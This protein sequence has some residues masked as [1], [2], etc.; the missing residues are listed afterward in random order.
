[1]INSRKRKIMIISIVLFMKVYFSRKDRSMS[2]IM[3]KK[4]QSSSRK[5]LTNIKKKK[6]YNESHTQTTNGE[7]K[8]V[9]FDEIIC[10]TKRKT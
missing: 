10:R 3:R 2:K 6:K 9:K 1:M 7:K 8:G 4:N 5:A